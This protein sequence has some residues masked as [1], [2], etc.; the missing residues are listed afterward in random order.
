MGEGLLPFSFPCNE[1]LFAPKL[2]PPT[3]ILLRKRIPAYPR[4]TTV[5]SDVYCSAA[6]LLNCWWERIHYTDRRAALPCPALP[7]GRPLRFTGYLRTAGPWPPASGVCV[8]WSPA[9][10]VCARANNLQSRCRCFARAPKYSRASARCKQPAGARATS[11]RATPPST[12]K[13]S[14]VSYVGIRDGA[15]SLGVEDPRRLRRCP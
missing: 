15:E 1:Q 9:S 12:L 13:P 14:V 2:S 11:G 8:P 4:T 5:I 6:V 3:N 7:C 10:G